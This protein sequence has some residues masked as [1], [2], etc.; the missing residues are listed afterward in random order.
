M[1]DVIVISDDSRILYDGTL[2]SGDTVLVS[3]T[4]SS[5]K[6][7][8][9]VVITR[10]DKIV[11]EIHTSCSQPIGV[12]ME[13]GGLKVVTG[14]SVDG[15]PFCED[16][17]EPVQEY[18]T[19]TDS[20]IKMRIANDGTSPLQISSIYAEWPDG[21]GDLVKIELDGTIW[22][23]SES[24]PNATIDSNWL[25]GGRA[26]EPGDSQELKLSFSGAYP[27]GAYVLSV[28][29]NNDE[30]CVLNASIADEC[31]AC[32]GGVTE[33]EFENIGLSNEIT[34]S[35]DSGILYYGTL[36]PGETVLVKG[37]ESSGKFKGDV[38]IT[39][40]GEVV[41][42][43]HTSCSQPIGVGMD[44]GGLKVVSGRSVDGGTFCND[45]EPVVDSFSD[46][47]GKSLE[48]RIANDGST[49]LQIS[50]ITA[51]WTSTADLIKI[52]LDG[53]IW[54]GAMSSGTAVDS[55]W[56]SDVKRSID[57]GDN[58]VLKLSFSDEIVYEQLTVEFNNN[59][60]LTGP[61]TSD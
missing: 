19:V 51:Q 5:G 12:G 10:N 1:Y 25:D 26:I 48:M 9:D 40:E 22:E 46:D 50:S 23:G 18:F 53:T 3:G 37:T 60:T 54:E 33:L 28:V 42:K 38:E 47:Y 29:F 17:C 31:S 55:N 41:S 4:E 20:Q 44:F 34:I 21:K 16:D 32:S 56:L 6:F 58:D 14:R 8:G 2:G 15:G 13:F 43:I 35:D 59:C 52:E 7:K 36:Q 39:R 61:S 24:S 11:A 45:C 27:T 57:A 49:P 30:G